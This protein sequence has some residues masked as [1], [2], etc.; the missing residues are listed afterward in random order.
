MWN[1]RIIKS[2]KGKD[3]YF[4]IYEVFYDEKGNPNSCTEDPVEVSSES[5]KGL[6]WVLKK[7]ILG[8]KKPVLEYKMFEEMEKKSLKESKKKVNIL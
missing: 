7:M 3:A 1:F 6:K 4:G 8:S 5:M 2:G